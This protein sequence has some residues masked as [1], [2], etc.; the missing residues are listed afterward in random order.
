MSLLQNFFYFI[1][2]RTFFTKIFISI[3]ISSFIGI[4]M[5]AIINHQYFK[6]ILINNEMERVQQSINQS[7][8][9][10]DNLLSRIINDMDY[11]ITYY[12]SDIIHINTNNQTNPADVEKFMNDLETFQLRFTDELESV[13]YYKEDEQSKDP[14]FI[15]NNNLHRIPNIIYVE[16]EWYKHYRNNVDLPT[17]TVPTDQ[18]LFYQDRS[19]KTVWLTIGKYSKGSEFGI[20]VIR[21]N[22]KIFSDLFR[23]LANDD[24]MIEIRDGNG[25]EVYATHSTDH[26]INN[27]DWL[28]TTSTLEKSEFN[29]HVFINK[30][31]I[32]DKVN[33]V[34]SI[35]LMMVPLILVVT[36]LFSLIL[37]LTLS[38]PIKEMLRLLKQVENGN[39]D[40]RFPN[41]YK[42]EIGILGKGFNKMIANV[43]NLIDQVFVIKMD[44]LKMELK[45]K[46]S[47]ILAMQNQI[48]PHFLYNTL[49]TINCHAIVHHVP[50]I[51]NMSQ[52]LA[53]FFRYSIEKNQII[54]S[55]QEEVTHVETYL[56]ILNERYPEIEIS[57]N[58][59]E[60]FYSYSIIKLSLQPLIEN[61]FQH[62]FSGERDYYLNIYTEDINELQYSV[63]IEDNGE[64]MDKD[65]LDALNE[66]LNNLSANVDATIDKDKN[67][68]SFHHG[69]GILNVHSRIMLSF[70]SSHGVRLKESMSGGLLIQITLPKKGNEHETINR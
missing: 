63:C 58:I 17:W 36:F 3:F 69:I 59:P 49:E 47:T 2:N 1:M 65:K 10:L 9:N 41:R 4:L 46:E 43:K 30:L 13:F 31:A 18:H 23:E 70:G 29:I 26:L 56:H 25:N 60:P 48:N 52:A 64:G 66:S 37:S 35:N 28:E 19:Q 27:S 33:Q 67:K 62:A 55:L 32:T 57:I 44:K 45:Q 5:I 21:I 34:Q 11:F 68:K 14:I 24:L 7:A 12:E 38:R 42:D 39:F 53:D 54:V 22:S 16:H 50:S 20:F 6:H 51:S 40:V 61:A 8:V 15:H